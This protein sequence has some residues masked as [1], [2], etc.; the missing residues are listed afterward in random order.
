MTKAML[1]ACIICGKTQTAP[2][3]KIAAKIAAGAGGGVIVFGATNAVVD[4]VKELNSDSDYVRDKAQ[5]TLIT[6]ASGTAALTGSLLIAL[7]YKK[8]PHRCKVVAIPLVGITSIFLKEQSKARD[9][10]FDTEAFHK[11]SWQAA[12]NKKRDAGRAARD[13]QKV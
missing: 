10:I 12:W 13:Q 8:Y 7:N 5:S 3:L 11:I 6:A 9:F 4:A 2:G 1:L